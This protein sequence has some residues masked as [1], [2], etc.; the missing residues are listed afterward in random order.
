MGA[1]HTRTQMENSLLKRQLDGTKKV[2]QVVKR[3]LGGHFNHAIVE[4]CKDIGCEII[5]SIG[6]VIINVFAK[7]LCV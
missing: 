7:N 3:V 4:N 2:K 1:S 6:Y 5:T